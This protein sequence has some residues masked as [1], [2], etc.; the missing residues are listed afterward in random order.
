MLITSQSV[1]SEATL[2]EVSSR[3]TRLRNPLVS[4]EAEASWSRV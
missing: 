2:G 1:I 3:S 4:P